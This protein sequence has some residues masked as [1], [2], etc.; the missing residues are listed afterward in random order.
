MR[1]EQLSKKT[2]DTKQVGEK[3]GRFIKYSNGTVL[4]IHTNLLWMI[5]DFRTI[6]GRFLNN[7]SWNEA[8]AW[9]DKINKQQYAGYNDWHVPTIVEYRTINRNSDDRKIYSS[10]FEDQGADFFWSR[11]EISPSVASYI[12]FTNGAAVSGA[13][14]GQRNAITGELFR[15]SVRLVRIAK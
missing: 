3:I 1:V 7:A 11:N 6:E 15:V 14:Q 13:K 8:M 12:Y 4:D 5:E 9:A 10:V 2:S